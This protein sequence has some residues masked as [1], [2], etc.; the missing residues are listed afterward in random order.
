MDLIELEKNLQNWKVEHDFENR[1]RDYK[2][3][4]E[5][6]QLKIFI[7]NEVVRNFDFS[8]DTTGKVIFEDLDGGKH[9]SIMNSK[10]FK[11]LVDYL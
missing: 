7:D 6:G 3:T 2:I 8:V 4:I 5:R 10:E 11:K 9:G 1:I